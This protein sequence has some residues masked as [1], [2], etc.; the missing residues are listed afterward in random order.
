MTAPAVEWFENDD[1]LPPK[2]RLVTQTMD[3]ATR[4]FGASTNE[5]RVDPLVRLLDP[6]FT[7]RTWY[8]E[9]SKIG[10]LPGKLHAKQI[11]ALEDEAKHRWLF[12]GN[13]G[14]KMLRA[15]QPVLTPTG[16]VAI[17]ALRVGDAVIA[18]DGTPTTV[19]G[20][21]PQG[22]KPMFRVTFDDGASV[23]AG[24]EHQWKVLTPEARFRRPTEARGDGYDRVA[25]GYGAW[26]VMTTGAM[27]T[28]WGAHPRPRRRCA[29]PVPNPVRMTPS[30]VLLDPYL[31][32]VLLGDGG[33]TGL[34]PNLTNA[35]ASLL[36]DV[37]ALLPAPCELRHADRI[38]YRLASPRGHPNPVTAALR[39]YGLMGHGAATKFVPREYLVNDVAVRLAVLQGLM[40]TDGT[41][42]AS[43]SVSFT[44]ISL[45]L[46]TD[47]VALV[48]S[49]GGKA[50]IT[51]RITTYTHRGTR[52]S[53]RR[54]YTVRI[55]LP[56]TRVFR[57]DR[58]QA[59]CFDPVS[60]CDERV[61]RSI[62]PE[63]EGDAVCIAIAHPDATY[64]TKEYIV[65]H[66][67]TTGVLDLVLKALGR[68]PHQKLRA[69]GTRRKRLPPTTAWASALTWELWEKILLPEFLTWIPP[70]RIIDAPPAF[71]HSTRRD[72]IILADNGK[73]SR[74][75]GKAAQQG[76]GAYQSARV[77]DVLLDEEHPEAVWDEMQ[78]RLLRFGGDT[79]APMTPLLGMT[80]VHGRVYEPVKTGR[81]PKERHTYTHA[82]IADNPGIEP[83]AIEEVKA[84]LAHNPTQLEARL[85][86][87]FTRP[88]GAVL[89]WD[90]ETHLTREPIDPTDEAK[91][92]TLRRRGAWYGA[93]DLGK[94]RF[95][96]VFGVA[97]QDANFLV[98]DEYFSQNEDAHTRAKGIDAILKKWK[99]PDTISIPADCA[100]PAGIKELN[101]ELEKIGSPYSTYAVNGSFKAKTAGISRV[102]NLLNRG[103]WKVRRGMGA[104]MAWRLGMDA[105][106]PGK[107][108][109]SSRWMYEAAMWQ[110]PKAADGKV[111]KDEPDD[112]T[113]D[114]ADMMDATRYL[115]MTFFP[116]EA[117][118]KPKP[119]DT[120]AERLRKEHERLERLA[121]E[122]EESRN[123]PKSDRFG[124]V[125]R[126]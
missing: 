73:E 90:P 39:H 122:Y 64:V 102:E 114:G 63:G 118:V 6:A 34:T 54:S 76:A 80:W 89:P 87:H 5:A 125:L 95:A 33:L 51:S 115:A 25:A 126:Q 46:A 121:N 9:H 70:W 23:L 72:I 57:L 123:T 2:Q 59:R 110:Y 79:I 44:S 81:I 11:A 3:F 29:I 16:W 112:A 69:D 55:R 116:A 31:M 37:R 14:G 7:D 108:V 43:G 85:Y 78:P 113:A 48:R 119:N 68:H 13:Q 28:R 91:L 62:V 17:G 1:D 92:L 67:T 26:S 117:P 75:T 60:T 105:S 103:A 35:D 93:I 42:G 100:D 45:Q 77:D 99:V 52:H 97:D 36:A 53:G 38:S 101:D 111:Q 124:G 58:K 15:D 107:P 27:R 88:H 21:F 71:K 8:Y 104:D 56:R 19:V 10:D 96:F 106:K 22:V 32:G 98:V 18:G 20:V 47:V 50:K 74:I 84:E 109:I 12:W 49:L 120:R 24:D 4:K 86:G 61:L 82:G 94:W 65:T 30:P 83:A 40:D 66:N 41:V